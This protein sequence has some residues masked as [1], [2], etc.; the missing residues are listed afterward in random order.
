[1]LRNLSKV[2]KAGVI[3]AVAA[4]LLGATLMATPSLASTATKHTPVLKPDNA[5]PGAARLAGWKGKTINYLYFTDGPDEKYTRDLVAQF[6]QQT[7]INVNLQII[8][9]A[10]LDSTLAARL[11]AGNP[12]DLARV[13]S[14]QLYVN[15]ALNLDQY[16]GANYRKEFLPGSYTAV[17]DKNG[18]LFGVPSDLTMNGPLIN[19][20]LFKKAGVP[21]PSTTKPWTWTEMLA[22]AKK[23]QAA[24]KTDYAF[25]ID[26]SGHRLS[27]VLSQYGTSLI[28]A[29][30]TNGL[31]VAKATKALQPLVDM[32][33]ADQAPKDLWLGSGA[34][35]AAPL[36]IFYAQQVPV[37]L[38]GN[39][40]VAA[41]AAN[42]KFN[43]AAAPNPCD[44]ACGGFPGGK[45]EI[46]FKKSANPVIAAYFLNWLNKPAEQNYMDQG[47][48]WMPTRVDLANA[49]IKYPSNAADMNVF[50]ADSA[51]TPDLAYAKDAQGAAFSNAA[52]ALRDGLTSV[53]A[54]KTTLTAMLT[55]LKTKID[56]WIVK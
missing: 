6:T 38:S 5:N 41:L 35:Y 47:S 45:F 46:A 14:P 1:M 3:A 25:A 42:A 50:I 15:D 28:G 36:D 37:Y 21:L 29:G 56:G 4:S 31:D 49:G 44:V 53:I 8:P 12:P 2:R 39:W 55:D 18:G 23:V 20:D 27:T 13:A 19:V 24:T 54:G 52:N 26:K 43:W 48:F 32:Y 40:Q 10:N 9:F 51:R 30:G 34:K 11:A 17:L 16:F 33:V 22:A 7:G